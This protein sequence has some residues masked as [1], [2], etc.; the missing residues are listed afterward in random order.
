MFRAF[1]FVR[2]RLKGSRKTKYSPIGTSFSTSCSISYHPPNLE[3]TRPCSLVLSPE[4]KFCRNLCCFP[5]HQVSCERTL[6]PSSSEPSNLLHWLSELLGT[7]FGC[8]LPGAS[9]SYLSAYG[10]S[11]RPSSH[12]RQLHPR[13]VT[14]LPY[15]T[16][17]TS[18]CHL[19]PVR[20]VEMM[21]AKIL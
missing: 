11:K 13:T 16:C 8:A 18:C 20:A 17:K 4:E 1:W 15:T 5:K 2:E 3:V 19:T 12:G 6:G 14:C 9:S 21:V 10:L 7:S